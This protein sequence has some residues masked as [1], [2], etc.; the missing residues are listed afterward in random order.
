MENLVDEIVPYI[1]RVLNNPKYPIKTKQRFV[2]DLISILTTK[3]EEV[4]LEVERTEL[5]E[6]PDEVH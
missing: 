1:D 4:V 5:L 2:E 6:F 3:L